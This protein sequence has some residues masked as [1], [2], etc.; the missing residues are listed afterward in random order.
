MCCVKASV[1][2]LIFLLIPLISIYTVRRIKMCNDFFEP[3][4]WNSIKH[5]CVALL[6]SF[7]DNQQCTNLSG[8]Q[9]NRLYTLK[10]VLSS[11]PVFE[12]N[13]LPPTAVL[14]YPLV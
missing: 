7:F 9:Y 1:S 14:K 10:A 2:V 5:P 11:S 3:G 4:F 8:V 13:A 6:Y 12:A